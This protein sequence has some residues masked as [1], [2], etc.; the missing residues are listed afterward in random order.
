MVSF[1]DVKKRE[2]LLTLRLSNGADP[3]AGPTN[4]S[5]RRKPMKDRE[6]RQVSSELK[7]YIKLVK[8]RAEMT[9]RKS[10]CLHSPACHSQAHAAEKRVTHL[11]DVQWKGGPVETVR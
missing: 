7:I 3:L 4:E 1:V 11:H 10:A 8:R 2:I 6:R 9:N 5:A